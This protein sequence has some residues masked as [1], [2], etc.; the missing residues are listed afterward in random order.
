MSRFIDHYIYAVSK[1]MRYESSALV[2]CGVIRRPGREKSALLAKRGAQSA[3]SSN[4]QLI[5]FFFF[6]LLAG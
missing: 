4:F 2:T 5:T 1:A 6:A 3:R